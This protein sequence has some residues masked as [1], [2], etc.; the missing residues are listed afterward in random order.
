[1]LT[2]TFIFKTPVSCSA[3][4]YKFGKKFLKIFLVIQ[5]TSAAVYKI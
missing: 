5:V 3:A 2:W 4:V 1:M